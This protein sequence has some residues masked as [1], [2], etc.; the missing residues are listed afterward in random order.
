MIENKLL[1]VIH[2]TA[3]QLLQDSK[4]R[5]FDKAYAEFKNMVKSGVAKER[6]YNI[7]SIDSAHLVRVQFNV[8]PKPAETD[9]Q[10]A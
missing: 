2:T 5:E 8:S 3:G 9:S 4:T 10:F 6:G 1:E 7:L